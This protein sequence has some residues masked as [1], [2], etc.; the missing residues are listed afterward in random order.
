MFDMFTI[1]G[2]RKVEPHL[3]N[4]F[5]HLWMALGMAD[6][7]HAAIFWFSSKI[8]LMGFADNFFLTVGRKFATIIMYF[9]FVSHFNQVLGIVMLSVNRFTAII[10]PAKSEQVRCIHVW[11]HP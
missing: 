7:S 8:P 10:Y 6:L 3:K 4:A 5:F 1:L 9:M 11:I 2:Y